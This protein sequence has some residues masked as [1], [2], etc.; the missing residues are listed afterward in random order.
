M[1]AFR[2]LTLALILVATTAGSTS[3]W[4]L[5]KLVISGYLYQL[6]G[7]PAPTGNHTV[8]VYLKAFPGVATYFWKHI[9]QTL[10]VKS[11]GYFEIP[12]ITAQPGS[13]NHAFGGSAQLG[14]TLTTLVDNVSNAEPVFEVDI[15][16]PYSITASTPLPMNAY[17]MLAVKAAEARSLSS[18]TV[19]MT[20]VARLQNTNPMSPN[21]VIEC[22]TLSA[23]IPAPSVSV[24]ADCLV[25]PPRGGLAPHWNGWTWSCDLNGD[26]ATTASIRICSSHNV[27]PPC[28]AANEPDPTSCGSIASPHPRLI[29]P[30]EWSVRLIE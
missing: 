9:G 30:S 18:R 3:A 14:D 19:Q 16:A 7:S 28:A 12:L 4:A 6:D 29:V 26:P 21:K 5:P 17:S 24:E 1:K 11:D 2:G 23:T 20:N 25:R 10:Y 27:D 8:T 13:Y 22:V 15:P